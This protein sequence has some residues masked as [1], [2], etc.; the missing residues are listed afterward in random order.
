MTLS[1]TVLLIH[2]TSSSAQ[3]VHGHWPDVRWAEISSHSLNMT[4]TALVRNVKL[5]LNQLI[6][7]HHWLTAFLFLVLTNLTNYLSDLGWPQGWPMSF[8]GWPV[9]PQATPQNRHRAQVNSGWIC[10]CPRLVLWAVSERNWSGT[11]QSL[12]PFDKNSLH[13][14]LYFAC[15]SLAPRCSHALIYIY[16]CIPIFL[17]TI[18]LALVH[19]LSVCIWMFTCTRNVLS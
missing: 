12:R 11:V 19:V 6:C 4:I 9:T 7:C 3:I 14:R 15:S 1:V 17:L 18:F 13:L 8:Q 16:I 2:R 10:A 5:T